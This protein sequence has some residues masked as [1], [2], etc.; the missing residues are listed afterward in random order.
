MQDSPPSSNNQINLTSSTLHAAAGLNLDS[1]NHSPSKPLISLTLPNKPKEQKG[2]IKRNNASSPRKNVTFNAVPQHHSFDPTNPPATNSFVTDVSMKSTKPVSLTKEIDQMLSL[3]LPTKI[4]MPPVL[5][6]RIPRKRGE[7]NHNFNEL[8]PLPGQRPKPAAT[9]VAMTNVKSILSN[10]RK[11][12]NNS[13]SPTEI[14]Q[15]ATSPGLPT[16]NSH[17]QQRKSSQLGLKR[18]HDSATGHTGVYR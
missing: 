18:K 3:S 7:N 13:R 1:N 15:K 4:R 8:R 12:N 14:R 10:M 6:K 11:G 2:I 5:T 9:T 17:S 16:M